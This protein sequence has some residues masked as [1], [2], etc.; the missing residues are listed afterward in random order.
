[1][2]G[3]GPAEITP[4]QL[5]VLDLVSRGFANK[6]IANALD[7]SEPGVKKHVSRLMRQLDAP[8]RT[9]LVRKAIELHLFGEQGPRGYPTT[10]D[11]SDDLS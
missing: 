1:M 3:P 7:L 5:A 8:N 6:Q 9:A 10:P 4:R 2:G 11:R